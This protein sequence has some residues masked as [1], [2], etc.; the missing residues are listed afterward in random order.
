MP[1]NLDRLLDTLQNSDLFSA[2]FPKRPRHSHAEAFQLFREQARVTP[3]P[4]VIAIGRVQDYRAL[5]DAVYELAEAKHAAAVP[6]LAELWANCAL[7]PVRTSAGHALRAIGTPEARRALLDL[8]EDSDNLSVFLAVAAVFDEDPLRAFDRLS[9]Y[10][11]SERVA[12]PGGAVIPNGILW[13]FVPSS[14]TREGPQWHHSAAP[15]WLRQDLRWVRLC[16][17]LRRDIHLGDVAR[18]VLRYADPEIVRPALEEA[19]TSEGPRAVRRATRGSGDLLARYLRG[20]H[21]SVWK[22][23]RSH[24]ALGG[25]LLEEARA[26]AKETM[27]RV[28]RSAD[29]LAERLDAFGWMPLC[30]ALRTRPWVDDDDVMRQ[31]EEV[32]GAPLP[33]SLR[34]FWEVVGGIDWVWDYHRGDAPDLGVDLPMDQMDPL[35][36]APPGSLEYLFEMWEEQKSGVDPE[37][38]DP[39]SLELAPDDLHKANISGGAPYGIDLPFHGADPIFANEAHEL[40]FVDYLRFCFRWG[41]FPGLDRHA[42]RS[43]VRQFLK[44]MSKDLEPF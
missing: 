19:Q 6:L 40:P 41:G 37:L 7:M 15:L 12:Q 4:G 25:D 28:A 18:D 43:D 32:T 5:Q 14:F 44:G 31:M 24:E 1:D 13:T 36:V 20:E 29:V 8:I 21:D 16:I 38:V 3:D 35:C 2:D 11:A 27:I 23:L 33:V 34:A 10:F 39:F 26:V 9:A 30:S 42:E 22:E 17:T